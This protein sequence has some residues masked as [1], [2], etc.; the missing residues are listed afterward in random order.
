MYSIT[1]CI[2]TTH[3]LHRCDALSCI[4]R[5]LLKSRVRALTQPRPKLLTR[6]PGSISEAGGCLGPAR[7]L[8]GPEGWTPVAAVK[9]YGQLISCGKLPTFTAWYATFIIQKTTEKQEHRTLDRCQCNCSIP[10]F[11]YFIRQTGIVIFIRLT[12]PPF[13][14]SNKS[15]RKKKHWNKTAGVVS[16]LF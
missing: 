13:S 14:S 5:F 15:S 10:V 1:E 7:S 2:A 16:I 9:T 3:G 6:R 12:S 4:R 11:T 8:G